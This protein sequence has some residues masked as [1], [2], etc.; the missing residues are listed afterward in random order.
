MSLAAL[1]FFPS[2]ANP[3]LFVR[4]GSTPF[5]VLV[6][7][8]DL[9]FATPDRRALAS[10]KEEM[11]RRHTCTDLGELR[12]YLGLQITR[13]RAARTI[14]LTQLHMVE[15]ILTR[16]CFPFS[17]VQPTPL[18]VDHGL[19]T[20]PLEEPFESSGPYP[21]LRSTRVSF[22]SSSSCEAEVYVAA[23]ATQELCWLSFL[24]TDLGERPRSPP[25]LFADNRSAILLCEE[26]RLV[27][28]A[29]HIQLHYFLLRELQQRGQALVQRVVSEAN[30]ADI[31][32]KALPPCDHQRF[33]TQIGLDLLVWRLHSH[34]GGEFSSRLL[35]DFCG[36]EGIVQSFTL[37]ASPQQNGIAEC[38]IGLVM[39]VARTSMIHA[40]APHFLWPF[41]VRYAAHQLNLWPRVSHPETSPTV[42][43]TGE[44]GDVS[45]FRA[46]GSLSLVRDLP[47]GKL[48]LR[49]L[50]CV[51]LGFPTNAPSWQFYHPGSRRVLSSC[52]VNFDE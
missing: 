14:T 9:V 26:P 36:A 45:E 16:F 21:E 12:H 50:R 25:V 35:K 23:M 19:T 11:Q 7:V 13:D 4:H 28:K 32:T 40:A 10:V 3:S 51:F 17:K 6:Y 42:R 27:G 24:L 33:C 41:A 34:R 44:V 30:T 39:E 1:D 2:S 46:W 29:K 15:Q 52:D 8:D 18:D 43:W 48:S 20:P 38:R 49:T 31:F 22:V 47:A 37:L 5:F